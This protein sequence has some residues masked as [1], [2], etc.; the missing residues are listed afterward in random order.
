MNKLLITVIALFGLSNM[1]VAQAD[2]QAGKAKSIT[3][4]A[5]HGADGNSP[6]NLY[7][8][9]A[10]QH[11][12]YLEK[13]LADFKSG[14]RNDPIMMGMVMALSAQ[15]IK[16]LATYYASQTATAETVSPE[17]A[18]AGKKL[19]MGGDLK[20]G[21]PGC[22]ACHGPRGNGLELAKFPK[23]SNQHPA[24][25]KV[26]LDKFRSKARNN[27]ANG[28]MVDVAT[29]LTDADIELLSKYISALH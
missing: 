16:D 6:S 7:P 14:E 22:T 20:R 5:C 18:D 10:G 25:T 1:A 17:I 27:D 3:C 11:K 24:Y 21:I 4:A 29:K 9:L 12:S 28:M 23:I 8:K 13:Q 15:D 2:I 26:Q 19:Y